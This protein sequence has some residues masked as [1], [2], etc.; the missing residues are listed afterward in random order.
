MSKLRSGLL[1][2]N[3]QRG[4]QRPRFQ[5]YKVRDKRFVLKG[6]STVFIYKAGIMTKDTSA[7]FL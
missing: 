3:N 5:G 1:T 6:G 4:R 7:Y 2:E